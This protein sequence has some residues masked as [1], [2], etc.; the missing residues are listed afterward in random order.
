MM[1]RKPGQLAKDIL[2]YL[3]G[4]AQVSF[5]DMIKHLNV[6]GHP[7]SYQLKKLQHKGAIRR[8]I[9]TRRYQITKRGKRRLFLLNEL[10]KV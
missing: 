1:K 8:D 3:K 10:E 9:D 4:G 6:V 5:N 7:L 2:E